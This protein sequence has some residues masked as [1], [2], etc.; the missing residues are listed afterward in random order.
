MEELYQLLIQSQ[1]NL[2]GLFQK[3]WMYHWNIMGPDFY[4]YHTML[5]NQYEE[6]FEEID[7]LTEHMRYLMI[8]PIPSLSQVADMS[9]IEEAS[10]VLTAMEMLSQLKTDNEK[11]ISI[12]LQAAK[13]ADAQG[14]LA[15]ANL[16]QDL[17]ESH[18]KFVWM[19][20]V[21]AR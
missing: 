20:R 1:C 14:Q 5:G 21:I 17:I 18:G 10:D 12:F 9:S 3:T 8:K 7:R 13:E 11:L 15:T 19:L 4:Q 16:I 6:M 2:F